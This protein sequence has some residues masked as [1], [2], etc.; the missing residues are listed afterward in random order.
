MLRLFS[1]T[2]MWN[3]Y[4]IAGNFR[5]VLFSDISKRPFSSK[6]NSH[7]RLFFENKF[8]QVKA[9]IQLLAIRLCIPQVLPLMIMGKLYQYCAN[10]QKTG[11]PEWELMPSALESMVAR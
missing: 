5:K 2:V 9:T 8:P 1:K 3:S 6:I 7:V 11:D 10:N 4:R